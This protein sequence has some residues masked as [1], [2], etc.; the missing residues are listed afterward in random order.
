[1]I[2]TEISC[3]L[4]RNHVRISPTAISCGSGSGRRGRLNVELLQH[5]YRERVAAAAMSATARSCFVVSVGSR[6]ME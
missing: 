5:L 3:T 6:L 4:K 2:G 1:M